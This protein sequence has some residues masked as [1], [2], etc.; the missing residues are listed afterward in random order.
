MP[1]EGGI[2]PLSDYNSQQNNYG[3]N[4]APVRHRRSD[5]HHSVEAPAAPAEQQLAPE[6]KWVR[7]QPPVIA[8]AAETE[9]EYQRPQPQRVLSS[10]ERMYMRPPVQDEEEEYEEDE[11]DERRIPWLKIALA[12]LAVLVALCAALYF[13]PNAGPLTPVGDALRGLVHGKKEAG[14]VLSFQ[15]VNNE[16][17]TDSRLQFHVTTN[18]SVDGV[19]LEDQDGDEIVCNATVVSSDSDTNRIWNVTAVFDEPFEGPLFVAMRTGDTWSRTALSVPLTVVEPT[20]AP[21]PTPLP[22]QKPVVTQAPAAVPTSE[23]TAAP[24]RVSRAMTAIPVILDATS[25]PV[26]TWAPTNAPA[27]VV[28]EILPTA[29]PTEEPTQAPTQEPTQTP[30]P[31][32]TKAPTK[33]PTA[34]PTPSP[35][36]RFGAESGAG[37]LKVSETAYNE[38]GKAQK[39]YAREVSYI[40]PNPDHYSRFDIGVFTFRGDNFR[41]N[42]AFGTADVKKET[43]TVL[44]KSPIGSLRTADNGTLYGVGWTGQPAI[45]KWTKEVREMMNLYDEKK[46]TTG[47]REV[48]FGGQD[49]KIYFLD[50]KDG[51]ATRDPITVG[52]PLKGSVSVDTLGR[53]LISVGQG[54]SKLPNK[55]GDIGMHVYNLVDGKRAF[56]IN[57][58]KS[59]A[60]PVYSTNGAFDGTSLFLFEND[61]MVVAGENGLLYTI[62]L[63]SDFKY[64]NVNDP[65]VKGSL[66]V[67]K[68]TTF[69]RTKATAEKDAQVNVE[70][71]VAMYD[72]YVY[73]AD[74]YGVVRCV[75]TDT[76]KTVWAFDNG[77]NT[78]VIALDMEGNSG[79]SL[80][81]GN[82]CYARLGS[83]KK[84]IKD[85]S[86]RKLDAL[87]GQEIWSYSVKCTYDKDQLAGCKASPVVG[88]NKIKDLVIYTVNKVDGGGSRILALNK[89]TGEVKWQYALTAEAVSSPVA[90]YNDKGDA[91]I[92]QADESGTLTMLNGKTGEKCSTLD[93]GGKIQGSPAVYKDYLVI[94]TCSKDNSFMYGIKLN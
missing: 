67:N 72:K 21:T 33:A 89:K 63:N 79:V 40:A 80:Y 84:N 86:I 43:M 37:S 7:Q 11:E 65:D 19:R 39:N 32:P 9:E 56:L 38:K 3:A 66:D 93:L 83:S 35:M 13:I 64:P 20:P 54:I 61:A 31:K 23:P 88:Q 48:I 91:W 17:Y 1:D 87:T 42:A 12:A 58:R 78:D 26:A 24:T 76:M 5:R 2:F 16:G 18:K 45:I 4:A 29:D 73:M 94:G 30:T 25:I 74:T 52:F 44:W 90:V 49:G 8:P 14:Q 77:D 81:T 10:R 68:V 28:E 59:S 50:I 62:D 55:T 71:S 82:T 34:V 47:L 51:T 41:R 70:A 69:L 36:P 75:D 27:A 92:I 6:E 53:P 22:T 60:Q 46:N 15:A 85:V 57:G